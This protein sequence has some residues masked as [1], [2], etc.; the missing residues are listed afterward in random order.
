MTFGHNGVHILITPM[1]NESNILSNPSRESWHESECIPLLVSRSLNLKNKQGYEL[2]QGPCVSTGNMR[3]FYKSPT[4][5]TWG[6]GGEEEF[7][8]LV[9]LE[10][11]EGKVCVCVCVCARVHVWVC[12]YPQSMLRN[13]T[14]EAISVALHKKTEPNKLPVPSAF[15]SQSNYLED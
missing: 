10:Q 9:F 14:T 2:G 5:P 3:M 11:D 15:D 8:S 6:W 1:T 7:H 12:V 13:P 4:S